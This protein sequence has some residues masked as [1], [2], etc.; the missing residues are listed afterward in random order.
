MLNLKTKP[1]DHYQDQVLTACKTCKPKRTLPELELILQNKDI[2]TLFQPIIDLKNGT[3]FAFEALSRGPRDSYLHMPEP[4]FD[5]ARENSRLCVLDCLCREKS[6]QDFSALNLDGKLALNIDPHSLL[7]PNFETDRTLHMLRDEGIPNHKVILEL[8]EHSRTDCYDELRQAVTRYR[9]MGFTIALDDLGAGYSNLRLMAE[10]EP[11]YIKLDKYFISELS[12]NKKSY[13][14]MKM[15]VDLASE[16]NCSVI[17]EG[18]ETLLDLQTVAGLGIDYAQGYFLGR[19]NEKPIGLNRGFLPIK[20]AQKTR[21]SKASMHKLEHTCGE[22][23]SMLTLN[24]VA[25]C[26]S[27]TLASEVL[28]R[29]QLDITLQAVPVIDHLQVVGMLE[30]ESI[31]QAFSSAFGH[32]LNHKATVSLFMQHAPIV[33]K[34]TD[35]LAHVSEIA[36]HRP[37]GLTYAPL[38]VCDGTDYAGMV[39]IREL[40]EKITQSQVKHALQS[41]PL[42]GLPGNISIETEMENRLKQ[43]VSFVCCYFDLDNFKAF[44]DIYGFERGNLMIRLVADVLLELQKGDDFIGHVGGDDF[45]MISSREDWEK[46]V[47]TC[48]NN[49]EKAVVN[50]YDENHRAAGGISSLNRTGQQSYFP[51]SSLSVG[52]LPCEAGDYSSRLEI[53]SHLFQLK[54]LAKEKPGNSLVIERRKL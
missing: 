36:M 5:A 34:M 18:V 4:L 2:V 1:E 49:F 17:A 8:T 40:L 53:S 43:N 52:A 11:E 3:I 33:L 22:S 25:A 38:I 6:I 39:S 23:V 30:R 48:L 44:N 32:S 35:K 46:D 10:L 15:I 50:L 41:S 16:I 28:E 42:T 29:F 14:F 13:E 47:Q 54:H 20:K 37:V 19:P 27:F 26:S 31:L 24:N 12:K 51:F 45:V 7:D 9:D 21:H